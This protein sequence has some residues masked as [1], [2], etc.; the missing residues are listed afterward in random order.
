[1]RLAFAAFAALGLFCGA[2]AAAELAPAGTLRAT[3][4]D[5]NPVQGFIDAKTG[6][7][8]GPAYDL[9]RELGKTL[10]VPVKVSP[11]KGVMGV[12][13]SVKN[14]EADIGFLAFD[15]ARAVEVDYSR[16]Y[17]LGQNTFVVPENS[18]L[19]SVKDADRAGIALGVT[20]GDAGAL[21]LGRT[22]KSATLKPNKGGDMELALKMLKSGEIA[23]YGTN[24]QRLDDFARANPGLRLLPDNFYA[25]EQSIVVRKG[26]KALLDAVENFLDR[27]RA[28]GLVAK[29]IADAGLSGVDVAPA[30][31][32]NP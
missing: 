16:P 13:L 30:R 22:L 27:S 19:K 17:S 20:E 21:Y 23:A 31:P 8:R 1:M 11:A 3:Y 7:G 14:G 26:N 10:G 18:P 6:A 5:T 25:V 28:S 29:S 4:I 2:A 32:R 9:T 15:P 24:R 12:L